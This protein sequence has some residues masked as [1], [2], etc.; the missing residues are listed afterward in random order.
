MGGSRK[1][2]VPGAKF[3]Y[4]TV[5]RRASREFVLCHCDCGKDKEIQIDNLVNKRSRSCGCYV[6]VKNKENSKHGMASTSTGSAWA[7]MK[8]R[9]RNKHKSTYYSNSEICRYLKASPR[10]LLKV[11]GEKVPGSTLDRFPIHDGNYSCGRCK[12]CK[13]RGWKLNIRWATPKEQMLNRGDYNYKFSAFG[14]TLTIRE[15]ADL[16]GLGWMTIKSRVALLGWS[17]EESVT[18]PD[19][20]GRCYRP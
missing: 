18:T 5:I 8:G 13:R 16:S 10:N 9:V 11:I 4:L 20:N 3:S 15:W 6:A 17:P 19:K 2:A 14:K 1:E 12:E 7:S